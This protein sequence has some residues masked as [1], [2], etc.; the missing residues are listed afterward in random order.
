MEVRTEWELPAS[1]LLWNCFQKSRGVAE[2]V[3]NTSPSDSLGLFLKYDMHIKQQKKSNY[4]Y[5]HTGNI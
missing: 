1:E 3:Q 4:F 2:E 5:L